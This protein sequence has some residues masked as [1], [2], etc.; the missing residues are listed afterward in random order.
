MINEGINVVQ[1]ILKKLE[2]PFI[3]IITLV[4]IRFILRR[5]LNTLVAKRV[6]SLEA[7]DTIIRVLDIFIIVSALFVVLAQ[8]VEVYP[9]LIA[10]GIL[11]LVLSLILFDRIRDFIEYVRLRADGRLLNKPYMFILNGLEKP[12]YGRVTNVT[13]TYCIIEDL[14][15]DEYM[16]PNIL[17]HNAILKPHV[18]CLIF[19]LRVKLKERKDIE[20]I[21]ELVRNIKSDVF[22]V[23]ERKCMINKVKALEVDLKIAAHPIMATLR[24][25]DIHNFILELLEHFKEYDTEVEFAGIC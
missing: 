23:E 17:M 21:A 12:I 3:A 25:I 24:P 8:F 20:K 14:N 16:V 19:E 9:A 1:E 7:K 22:K 18:P 13:S 6:L 5:L 11:S 2:I 10:V 4:V 15:G